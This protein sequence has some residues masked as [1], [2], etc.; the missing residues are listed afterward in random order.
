M[1]PLT[2]G[3]LPEVWG[4]V[5]CTIVRL[6]NRWRD[7]SV[8]TGHRERLDDLDLIAELGIR[9]LRYPVLWET[10]SP[11]SPNHADWSWHDSRLARLRD[12]RITPIAGLLHHGSG[13]AY[14]DLLD[15]ELPEKLAK[16]A[17]AVARRYPWIE[18]FTPVNEP[19]TTARFSGLYGHWYPHHRS[20]PSLLRAL[21]N[22]CR[23]VVLSMQ[24]I[25]RVTPGAR[26]VQT[27]DLG[28]A[29]STPLLG[30][31]ADYEN[32][33][34]WLTF[35]LLTGRLTRGHELYAHLVENGIRE[36]ELSFFADRPCPPDV[37]GINH[38]LTSERFLE[39]RR[40]RL[41]G[42]RTGSNG[43]HRYADLEAVRADL[44]AGRTGPEA[45]L[46]EAWDRYR[47]PVAVTEVHHGCSRDEQLRWMDEVWNAALASRQRGADIRAVTVWA[48]FGAMDWNSLLTRRHG[49]YEVGAFDTRS[50]PPRITALGRATKQLVQNGRM[51]HPVL[52]TPGWWRRDERLYRPTIS[53]VIS[54]R[55]PRRKL[56]LVGAPGVLREG[57]LKTARH[58]GLACATAD[59]GIPDILAMIERHRPWAVVHTGGS[60]GGGADLAALASACGTA[61]LP[62]LTF[63]AD[64]SEG[65][66]DAGRLPAGG[67]LAIRTGPLFAPWEVDDLIFPLL[68]KLA[69]GRPF[70]VRQMP[71]TAPSYVP[72]LVHAALDLLIDGERG[73]WQLTNGGAVSHWAIARRLAALG[74]YDPHLVQAEAAAGVDSRRRPASGHCALMPS[75]DSALGRYIS[76][77]EAPVHRP[78]VIA[79]E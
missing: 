74:G 50:A 22:Q 64:P 24:A 75:L 41:Q 5:E 23:A 57:L 77:C 33:R 20:V 4:G 71:D 43:R 48:L 39:H 6:R 32:A 3:G 37:L 2:R 60:E 8:E 73:T 61:R 55:T 72:D 51:E 19:L 9:T 45:R 34:R 26:L 62:L 70:S 7:Q 13:P 63:G 58:R 40:D 78:D 79:A 1:D 76:E 36:D 69:L 46:M 29:F 47:L 30:Y 14:T 44:P 42:H 38:Y 35:D 25:R 52:D 10:V 49:H 11:H 28:K 65:A 27:E 67:V 21:I 17:E 16:H 18:S 54:L 12:L 56:L 15:R 66:P 53:K 31:Q 59:D 68:D